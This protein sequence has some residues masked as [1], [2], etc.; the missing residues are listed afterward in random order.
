MTVKRHFPKQFLIP[1]AGIVLGSLGA[2]G[3]G[4]S[5]QELFIWMGASLFLAGILLVLMHY[6]ALK[7]E[8]RAT[9]LEANDPSSTQLVGILTAQGREPLG[10]AKSNLVRKFLNVSLNQSAVVFRDGPGRLHKSATLLDVRAIDFD[11]NEGVIGSA[12]RIRGGVE[13][14]CNLGTI[15]LPV[16]RPGTGGFS[17]YSKDELSEILKSRVLP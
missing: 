16:V 17:F 15:R 12:P 13:I 10:L 14:R 5:F 4:S 7:L 9:A 2:I 8:R 6:P 3:N 11:I 1:V